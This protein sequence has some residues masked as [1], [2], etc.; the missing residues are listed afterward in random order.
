M[1]IPPPDSPAD[2][3]QPVCD[4]T[5]NVVHIE[6]NCLSSIFTITSWIVRFFIELGETNRS[7]RLS[8][9]LR[10]RFRAWRTELISEI[11]LFGSCFR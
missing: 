3:R 6:Q 10:R 1:L 5:L 4:A 11:N 8:H 9:D 7:S 2:L